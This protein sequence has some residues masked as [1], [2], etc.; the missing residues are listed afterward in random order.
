MSPEVLIVSL[1][2]SNILSWLLM[3]TGILVQQQFGYTNWK[4]I[5]LPKSNV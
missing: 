4:T 1:P 2:I 3:Q 5:E